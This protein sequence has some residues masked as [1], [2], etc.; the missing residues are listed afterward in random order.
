MLLSSR[1]LEGIDVKFI[2]HKLIFLQKK[3]GYSPLT[4]DAVL[5]LVIVELIFSFSVGI[6][7]IIF[8][9]NLLRELRSRENEQETEAQ[10]AVGDLPNRR[11]FHRAS[12]S[13]FGTSESGSDRKTGSEATGVEYRGFQRDDMRMDALEASSAHDERSL[14]FREGSES[15][16]AAPQEQTFLASIGEFLEFVRIW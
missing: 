6:S 12:S 16:A 8:S 9:C 2:E 13:A 15:A 3:M 5:A 1:P 7:C 4:Y 10:F 11:S 14:L